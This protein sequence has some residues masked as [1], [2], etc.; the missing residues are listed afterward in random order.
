MRNVVFNEALY[1]EEVIR[2]S[3]L[4][5]YPYQALVSVARYY[6]NRG[7]S[8]D[9]IRE[10]VNALYNRGHD[11]GFIDIADNVMKDAGKRDLA[12]IRFIPVTSA[13]LEA[14]Q[15]IDGLRRQRVAFALL[16]I[17]KY[18]NELYRQNHNWVNF[19]HKDIFAM[20]NVK[21]SVRDQY[22]LLN[23]LKTLGLIKYNRRV[24]NLD[25]R[26]LYTGDDGTAAGSHVALEIYDM[27]NLGF[28]Y[29]RH[30]GGPYLECKSCGA[31]VPRKSPRQMYCAECSRLENAKRAIAFYHKKIGVPS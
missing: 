14:I 11:C 19:R 27:R 2:T 23:D 10:R 9:T 30:L 16:V 26:V 12:D 5:S 18:Q 1:A 7:F 25:V 31:V 22:L 28:Q 8:A 3:D 21:V 24:D 13:E 4:G 20:A 15:A 29:M 17:S 6:M